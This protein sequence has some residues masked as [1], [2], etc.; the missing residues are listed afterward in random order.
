MPPE[1]IPWEYSFHIFMPWLIKTVIRQK[2]LYLS[3]LEG[4]E[5]QTRSMKNSRKAIIS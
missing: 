1:V 2:S 4:I 3:I 5:Q